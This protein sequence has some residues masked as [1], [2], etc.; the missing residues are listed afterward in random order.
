MA[1]IDNYFFEL[2]DRINRTKNKDEMKILVEEARK[3]YFP[4]ENRNDEL[5]YKGE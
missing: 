3:L 4:S 2:E 5:K 1:R